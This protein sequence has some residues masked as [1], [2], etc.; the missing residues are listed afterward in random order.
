MSFRILLS[1]TVLILFLMMSDANAQ[2]VLEVGP[3]KTYN[4][5]QTALLQAVAG[6]TVRLFPASYTGNYYVSNI[7]GRPGAWITFEGTD[8]SSVILRGTQ[9]IQMSEISYVHIRRMTI[10]GQ[11][12]NGMNIDDGGTFETPSHHIRFEELSFEDMNATGNNDMLKLS[13]IDTF[14]VHQ[15]TFI[16]GSAGGSGIDMVG[17]H[18]GQIH[19][20]RFVNQ[21]NSIQ[22]K[23]GCRFVTIDKNDFINGGDRTLN[24]GG[25]TGLAYFRPAGIN[26]EAADL[27]VHSNYFSGS[28]APVAFVGSRRVQVSNNTF[29]NPTKWIFR[30]LQES[31]DTSFFLSC[32]NNIFSNNIVYAQSVD[33]TVNIGP[34]TSSASFDIRNN[35]WYSARTSGWRGPA[36]PV[37]ETN[38]L[39]ALNPL[40]EDIANGLIRPTA[41]SPVGGKGLNYRSIIED[42]YNQKYKNPPSIGAV[43][44]QIASVNREEQSSVCAIY[45]M[46][47]H[48]HIIIP[49]VSLPFR[50]QLF[51]L[52]GQQLI[53]DISNTETVMLSALPAGMYQ[54]LIDGPTTVSKQRIIVY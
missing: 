29:Y 8:R 9:S 31:Q 10:R 54:L 33:P 11:S 43:E 19:H 44:F 37:A 25:S 53:D 46:P 2:R 26:Y 42:H 16:N 49:C 40:L 51:N 36:L 24:L 14:E 17:C 30:I 18:E 34:Y 22:V 48:D 20:S 45:P 50:Y 3:G 6:D 23:G 41:Q 5:P 21:G 13:G 4:D 38:G 32:A 28:Q 52:Y 15:C 1:A 12:A 7:H 39:Y 47:C 27:L 35:L